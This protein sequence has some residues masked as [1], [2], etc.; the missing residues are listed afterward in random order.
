MSTIHELESQLRGLA[1]AET[2]PERAELSQ[3][4]GAGVAA[5]MEENSSV[6]PEDSSGLPGGVVYLVR[7]I[8]TVVVPDV[9]ARRGLILALLQFS[10]APWGVELTL[11]E[12]LAEAQAQLVFVGDY[13]HAEARAFQRWIAA[14]EEYQGGFKRHEAMDREMTESLGALQMVAILKDAFPRLVHGMKG[15]HENIANE[16][17]EG[18]YPF[19]KFALEGAMVAEYMDRFYGGEP[20]TAAYRFEKNLPL[21]AVGNQFMVSHAE[22]RRAFSAR[23][24]VEYRGNEEVVSGFTWTG[25]GEAE[26]GSVSEMLISTF[27]R[28]KAHSALYFGGHRPIESRYA[29]RADGKYVQLHNP[30]RYIAAVLPATGEIDLERDVEELPS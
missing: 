5:L 26:E 21:L 28:E 16:H 9:H 24:V 8:P 4:L 23:E 1:E 6:R 29:L 27:G 2:P 7:D 20:F 17:G 12:A 10:L 3:I 15:N 13:V 11:L 25:N 19:R 14:F 22:P 18:N 30:E